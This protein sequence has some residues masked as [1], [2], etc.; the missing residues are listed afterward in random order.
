MVKNKIS[1]GE[2]Q[3]GYGKPPKESRFKRGHSGNPNGRPRGMKNLKT[4]LI[5]ELSERINV[6]EGGKPKKLSK[7]RALLKSLTAK[8]IKGDARAI[9]VLINLMVRV[10]ETVE[11]D[12]E[13][14]A[15]ADDDLAILDNFIAKIPSAAKKRPS[16]KAGKQ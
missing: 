10:L 2:Y 7:Q 4:D 5:E 15:I 16:R 8:A 6:S 3:V 1:L 13:V 14:L 9:S 12:R 11:A